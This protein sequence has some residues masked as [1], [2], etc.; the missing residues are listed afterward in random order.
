MAGAW[1]EAREPMA[2]CGKPLL[3]GVVG[4]VD[5]AKLSHSMRVDD[6]VQHTENC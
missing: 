4:T 1:A 5:S 3:F 2:C 6:S